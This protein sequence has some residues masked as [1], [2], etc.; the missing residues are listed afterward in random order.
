[1]TKQ[2]SVAWELLGIGLLTSLFLTM[3]QARPAYVDLA[4]AIVAVALIALSTPR[5]R[6]LW[7][8]VPA[9][10]RMDGRRAWRVSAIFTGV[11]LLGLAALGALLAVRGGDSW[12]ERLLNWHVLLAMGL[13]LPWALLQQYI[14]QFYLFGR[15]LQV[16]PVP[17][18]VAITALAF[19]AV[20]YPRWPVM[21]AT[22]L[23]GAVWTLIY[24]RWRSTLP[25]AAS[26]ALLG[27]AL[28]YWVLDRDLLATW[29][30][31]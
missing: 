11:A 3:F 18:A 5:S 24:Y 13:Y 20:H 2:K 23:A 10:A 16:M 28:H 4:L 8:L 19:A 6:R 15:L 30:P 12:A 21:A 26:H 31:P 17:V 25:L 7:Q 29:L 9:A 14:F 27:S 1:M 22:V